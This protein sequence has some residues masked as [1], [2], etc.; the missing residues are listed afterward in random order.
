MWCCIIV[1]NRG[2]DISDAVVF[3][4]ELKSALTSHPTVTDTKLL[5]VGDSMFEWSRG[6]AASGWM[7]KWPLR[8]QQSGRRTRRFFVLRNNAM[9]YFK[10][11]PVA[12]FPRSHLS[13]RSEARGKKSLACKNKNATGTSAA[14]NNITPSRNSTTNNNNNNNSNASTS[15]SRPPLTRQQLIR[16]LPLYQD[17]NNV[18]NNNND[19]TKTNDQQSTTM[20]ALNKQGH[21]LL[22]ILSLLVTHSFLLTDLMIT[23]PHFCTHLSFHTHLSMLLPRLDDYSGFHGGV[24]GAISRALH[25][26]GH[27]L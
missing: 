26:A 5:V 4:G 2:G 11:E 16:Q 9:F 19:S 10:D 15:F 23:I 1:T 6:A 8:S 14:N 13:F 25:P 20:T 21:A 7:Y 17:D 27:A 12:H 24:G 22:V 3:T 18:S